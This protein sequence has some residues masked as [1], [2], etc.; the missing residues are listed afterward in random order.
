MGRTSCDKWLTKQDVVNDILLD[1]NPYIKDY[2]LN[3]K[4][5][6]AIM[7]PQKTDTQQTNFLEV[8][9]LEKSNGVWGY[10]NMD[11]SMGPYYYNC[12]QAFIDM[13]PVANQ[14][15]RD[16]RV[17]WLADKTKTKTLKNS[18]NVGDTVKLTNGWELEVKSLV[19]F[20]GE[21][22][23]GTKY[24]IPKKMLMEKL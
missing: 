10:K 9:V 17:K 6:W 20:V 22:A 2:K 21:N 19:P 4:E 11:E 15:W 8:F 13:V 12:P 23:D 18:I 16:Q 14:E 3:G 24:R 5:L 1:Y 7:E